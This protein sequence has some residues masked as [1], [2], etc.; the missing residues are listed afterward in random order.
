MEVLNT[1]RNIFQLYC[2][3]IVGIVASY[4]LNDRGVGV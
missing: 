2:D 3:S 4:G 1:R